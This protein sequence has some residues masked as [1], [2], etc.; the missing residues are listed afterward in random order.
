MLRKVSWR[1]A[2]WNMRSRTVYLQ[3]KAKVRDC[4]PSASTIYITT[5][6]LKAMSP[7]PFKTAAF[8]YFGET[9]LSSLPSSH[10]LVQLSVVC[11][12]EHHDSTAGSASKSFQARYWYHPGPFCSLTWSTWKFI[13]IL[14]EICSLYLSKCISHFWSGTKRSSTTGKLYST[15]VSQAYPFIKREVRAI[16]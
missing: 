11:F 10:W 4:V 5:G 3:E 14:I 7:N 1:P 9:K 6:F 16:F 13:E 2:K 15:F 12:I 8:A